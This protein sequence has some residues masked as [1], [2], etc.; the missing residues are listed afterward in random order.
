MKKKNTQ[1]QHRKLH[2]PALYRRLQEFFDPHGREVIGRRCHVFAIFSI[3]GMAH[4]RT[5]QRRRY[6]EIHFLSR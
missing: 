1:Q 2:S 4:R 3:R 5:C 6:G